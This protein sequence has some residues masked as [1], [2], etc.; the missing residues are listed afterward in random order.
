MADLNVV[1]AALM[2]AFADSRS[3][4]VPLPARFQ[5]QVYPPRAAASPILPT[6]FAVLIQENERR[7]AI[8]H[9]RD[10]GAG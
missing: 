3:A 4:A 9:E 1:R 8:D 5:S 6:G 10:A 2:A 7:R